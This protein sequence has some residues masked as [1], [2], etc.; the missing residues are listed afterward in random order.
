MQ[1]SNLNAKVTVSK[2]GGRRTSQPAR[3]PSRWYPQRKDFADYKQ[4][5]THYRAFQHIYELQDQVAALSKSVGEA[6]TAASKSGNPMKPSPSPIAPSNQ[7][8]ASHI[9]GIAVKA[10]VPADGTK[11]TYVAK[12]NQFVFQ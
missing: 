9:M 6:A 8:S 10:G 2:V 4:W 12:Q 1:T 5:D 11:L 3:G 7:S